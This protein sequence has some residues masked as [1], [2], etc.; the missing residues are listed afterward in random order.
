MGK[1]DR[2]ITEDGKDRMR[3]V[4]EKEGNHGEG[5]KEDRTKWVNGGRENKA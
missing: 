1:A 3:E 5:M 2:W 4:R